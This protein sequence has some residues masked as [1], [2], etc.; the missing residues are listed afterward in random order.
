MCSLGSLRLPRANQRR[1]EEHEQA[2][3]TRDVPVHGTFSR[4]S[5]LSGSSI[6]SLPL[7]RSR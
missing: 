1:E 7:R 5:A 3:E 4:S 6:T 2:G